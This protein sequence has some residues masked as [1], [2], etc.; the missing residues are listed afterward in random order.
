MARLATLADVLA[1]VETDLP[2]EV[3][4]VLIDTAESEILTFLPDDDLACFPSVLWSG[5][6]D[7]TETEADDLEVDPSVHDYAT[8]RIEGIVTTASGPQAFVIDAELRD[9]LNE[10]AVTPRTSLGTLI[11]NAAFT[12]TISADGETLGFDRI[13]GTFVLTRI[14]GILAPER[15]AVFRKAVYDLVRLS[16][17]YRGYDR[18]RIGQYEAYPSDFHAERGKVLGRLIYGGGVSL[19]S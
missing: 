19:V 3:L 4:E 17:L 16:A 2:D 7:V 13:T 12:I 18:E 1:A 6:H 10:V 5:Y 15:V 14:L 8:T 9:G 11:E